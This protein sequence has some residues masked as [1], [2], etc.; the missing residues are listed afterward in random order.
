[1]ASAV[2]ALTFDSN[3]TCAAAMRCVGKRARYTYCLFVHKCFGYSCFYKIEAGESFLPIA[4][5]R[6]AK[7]ILTITLAIG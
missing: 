1:M 6:A 7:W 3:L 4:P 2:I 5:H